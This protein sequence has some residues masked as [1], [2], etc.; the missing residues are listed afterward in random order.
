M[1]KLFLIFTLIPL[2]AISQIS[3]YELEFNS[4]SLDYVEMPNTS[5]VITSSNEFSISCWVNPQS[6]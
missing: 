5:S 6:N 3:E 1:K 2:I 4:S